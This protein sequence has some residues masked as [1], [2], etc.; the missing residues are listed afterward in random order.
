MQLGVRAIMKFPYLFTPTTTCSLMSIARQKI[1]CSSNRHSDFWINSR[2][3]FYSSI[4][5]DWQRFNRLRCR[6]SSWLPT[7]QT[8]GVDSSIGSPI[9]I[10]ITIK[11]IP[12]GL[13]NFSFPSPPPSS[14][15]SLDLFSPTTSYHFLSFIA[16]PDFLDLFKRSQFGL[17]ILKT[18]AYA[19]LMSYY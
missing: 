19:D 14:T 9:S 12:S 3:G 15:I 1:G 7:L 18:S 5:C 4:P 6:K 16:I 2:T 13:A 17:P 10:I 8:L 11:T